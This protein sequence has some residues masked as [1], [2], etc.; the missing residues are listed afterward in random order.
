MAFVRDEGAAVWVSPPAVL[1]DEIV[2]GITHGLNQRLR[3]GAP[4]VALF[5]LSGAG[6]PNA[7]Q[8][9]ILASH[10]RSNAE[11]IEQWVRGLGVIAPSPVVRGVATAIFW[12]EPPRVPHRVHATA[13]EADA[14]ARSLLESALRT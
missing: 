8:R 10:M 2:L 1:S 14:W 13:G 3:R 12:L 11:L 9:Q 6:V 7:K 4:Y 5:D